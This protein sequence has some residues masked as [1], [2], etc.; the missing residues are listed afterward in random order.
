METVSAEE[1][2]NRQPHFDRLIA[3]AKDIM[4]IRLAAEYMLEK[5]FETKIN[6]NRLAKWK[7]YLDRDVLS[8]R[9]TQTV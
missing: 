4:D 1:M 8:I 9:I 3:E 5:D 7:T 2:E 6:Q